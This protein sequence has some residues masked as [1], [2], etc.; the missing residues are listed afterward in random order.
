MRFK[1]PELKVGKRSLIKR[2]ALVLCI[3]ALPFIFCASAYAREIEKTEKSALKGEKTGLGAEKSALKTEKSEVKG[4][5]TELK[6]EKSKSTADWLW[7]DYRKPVGFT[8]GAQARIQA[9][10]LWRGF[11]AGGPNIQG[12]ANVGYGGLYFDMWWNLGSYS[13]K[14]DAFQPEVDFTIG[15][16]RWGLNVGLIYIHN[17]DCGF[18]DFRNLQEVGNRLELDVRYTLSPKIPISILWASRIAAS[19]G[20]EN[21][22]G[23]TVRAFSSYLELSYT[24]TFRYDISLYGA[25]GVTPW[26]SIYTEFIHNFAVV[27]IDI[28]L[29]KD[30]SISERCGMML[31]GQMT[32]HPTLL[33][34]DPKTAQ[35][36]PYA[37]YS[38]SV[39]AN[40]TWGVYLK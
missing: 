23:D 38:Q 40:I 29:R 28:R 4:N 30:W 26:K 27:N 15:F 39:N 24:H 8:Y 32:I 22:K 33:A 20:Y 11:Y 19:D 25:V 7:E 35:W 5:K 9:A 37:P 12:D 31:Q 18:F 34:D 6:G 2:L 13:W 17:F 21:E 10:Y 16:N 3:G 36:K 14:F 1:F